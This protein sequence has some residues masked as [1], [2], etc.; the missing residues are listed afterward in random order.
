MDLCEGIVAEGACVVAQ[1][2]LIA[3]EIEDI[4]ITE[5]TP[6]VEA[7][8]IEAEV[9]AVLV[10]DAR[11]LGESIAELVVEPRGVIAVEGD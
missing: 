2:V 5:K 8:D 11:G 4:A 10:V 6:V 3:L 9:A 7:G 1:A